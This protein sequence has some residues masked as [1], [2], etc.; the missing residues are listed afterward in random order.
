MITVH[1]KLHGH[2]QRFHPEP[3]NKSQ[4]FYITLPY[5]STVSDLQNKLNLPDEEVEIAVVNH[6]KVEFE[7]KLSDGDFVGVL[8]LIAGG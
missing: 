2:L 5:D 8:P 1:V 3:E 7:S 4:P 6:E